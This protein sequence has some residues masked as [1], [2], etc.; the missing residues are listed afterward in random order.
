MCR[1]LAGS[2]GGSG[3]SSNAAGAAGGAAGEVAATPRVGPEWRR[4]LRTTQEDKQMKR[5]LHSLNVGER[6]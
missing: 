2:Y 1:A 5:E 6:V 4:K 3:F